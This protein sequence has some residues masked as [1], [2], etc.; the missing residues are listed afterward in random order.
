LRDAE[1][2]SFSHHLYDVILAKCNMPAPVRMADA[3]SV[4][5]LIRQTKNLSRRAPSVRLALPALLLASAVFATLTLPETRGDFA[6]YHPS[7]LALR[8][9]TMKRGIKPMNHAINFWLSLRHVS[10]LSPRWVFVRLS[11]A[12]G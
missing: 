3:M 5:T 12:F 1:K 4:L 10:A 9:D 2:F 11:L 7:K 6:P 8:P